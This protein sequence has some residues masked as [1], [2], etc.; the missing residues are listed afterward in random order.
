[1]R[2]HVPQRGALLSTNTRNPGNQ[3]FRVFIC[4][5]ISSPYEKS[6]VYGTPVMLYSGHRRETNH[7]TT[8]RGMA[9]YELKWVRDHIEVYR[10]GEFC[11]SADSRAEA[12]RELAA[13]QAA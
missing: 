2:Q 3:G 8:E 5:K 10:G 4:R 9:M 7:R 13:E 11:F 1:M 12:E 6:P